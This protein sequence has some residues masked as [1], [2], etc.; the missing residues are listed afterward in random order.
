MVFMLVGAL[1]AGG[2]YC[3]K[4]TPL[5]DSRISRRAGDRLHATEGRSPNLSKIR[6]PTPSLPNS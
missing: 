3:L 4:H 5:D 2:I 6:L 1:F